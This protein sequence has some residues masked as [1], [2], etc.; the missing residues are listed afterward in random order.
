MPLLNF[1]K[2][3]ADAVKSGSKSQ[4]IRAPRKH[5]IKR[6]DTLYLYTGL[7]TKNAELLR[8]VECESVS[9]ITISNHR[10]DF[11]GGFFW[12]SGRDSLE[13]FAI[14][15]GFKNWVEM[16]E[17]FDKT[18]GLPFKGTLIEW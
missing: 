9:E 4:T 13:S 6:G 15:D 11:V 3:F 14:N 17:W 16:I 12:L 18:H 10:V 2:Q 7:R 5:P 8:K 1:Q